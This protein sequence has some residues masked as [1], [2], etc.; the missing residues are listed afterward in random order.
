MEKNQTMAW[1][2]LPQEHADNLPWGLLN[3]NVQ[4]E[5]MTHALQFVQG[6]MKKWRQGW[7]INDEDYTSLRFTVY[8]HSKTKQ[9]SIVSGSFSFS[10]TCIFAQFEGTN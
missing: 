4:N 2:D 5:Y 1:K 8:I 10:F 6:F 9:M 3:I 7:E